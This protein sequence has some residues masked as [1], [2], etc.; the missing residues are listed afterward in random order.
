MRE[1]SSLRHVWVESCLIAAPQLNAVSKCLI[2]RASALHTFHLFQPHCALDLST[3]EVLSTAPFPLDLQLKCEPKELS[4]L[5]ASHAQIERLFVWSSKE[6]DLA[7]RLVGRTQLWALD[8]S[9]ASVEL[10]DAVKQNRSLRA[11]AVSSFATEVWL[12]ACSAGV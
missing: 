11:L 10:M 8:V 12:C 1:S 6:V 7:Q 9:I 2:A 5:L 4:T 3:V